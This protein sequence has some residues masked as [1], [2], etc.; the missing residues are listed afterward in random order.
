MRG[1]VLPLY[2][3]ASVCV[4]QSSSC[5]LKAGSPASPPYDSL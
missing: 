5:F 4:I 1:A 2:F 3:C